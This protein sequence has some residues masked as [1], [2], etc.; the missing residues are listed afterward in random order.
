MCISQIPY[1]RNYPYVEKNKHGLISTI[2]LSKFKLYLLT[3]MIYI[4]MYNGVRLTTDIVE[5]QVG[6]F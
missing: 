4:Y 6:M 3:T 5:L 2:S 1:R